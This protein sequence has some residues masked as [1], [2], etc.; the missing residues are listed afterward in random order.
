M[1][2]RWEDRYADQVKTAAEAVALIKP[3]QRVFVGTG[4]GMPRVLVDALVGRAAELAD[5]EVVQL[6]AVGETPFAYER[7][8]RNFRV[9]TFFVTTSLRH[10]VQGGLAE[11]IPIFFSDIPR[12]FD[13]G[14]IP[15]D[16][17]L[18]SVSPPDER[19][20]CT[21]G[22]SVDV[23]KSAAR[24]ATLVIAQ[25]NPLLPR[26]HGDSSIFVY[27]LDLLVPAS[28][29]LPEL[30][31]PEVDETMTR[32]GRHVAA[33]IEDG[34]TIEL[35]IGRVPHAVVQCLAGKRDLGLH[36]E[37]VTDSVIDL[38]ESG[39][40]TG[41][42]KTVDKGKIVASFAIGTR[43][44]YDF[45]DG[46]PAFA[47]QPTE[48][49][50]D[51]AVIASQYRMVAVNSALQVDL[52][53]QIAADSLG[54]SF[55]SGIGGQVDFNRG[56]AR[57][58]E[59]KAIIALPSTALKG[60][61]SRI[62][63][64]LDQGSG[65]VT[66][67]GDVQ[68]V[69]TEYGVAYLHGKSVQERAMA[70]IT[71]AHPDFRESLLQEAIAAKLLPPEMTDVQG[72]WTGPMELRTSLLL[73]DGT[74]ISFRPIHPTD[75]ESLRDFFYGMS[76]QSRYYRYMEPMNFAPAAQF[77]RFVYVDH[78]SNVRIVGTLPRPGAE[79][80]VATAGYFL[81]PTT[82]RAEVAF[83]VKDEWQGRSIGTFMLRLLQR[84]A[85][86]HG[87]AGF[88]AEV[89]RVNRAMQ[90][91]FEKAQGRVQSRVEDDVVIFDIDF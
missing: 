72:V 52:T 35:G 78:R 79:E 25:V 57:S 46:N 74:C 16:V 71:I 50:N 26:T 59:G 18:I 73:D 70:L 51:P 19:G 65:V 69:V 11:Y 81:D 55:F 45:I 32:I 56:A 76:A 39:A 8:R 47:F 12:L 63:T 40:V 87:I 85:K 24:N 77:R 60:K 27:D 67:R 3:G 5:V 9:S 84:V 91:V 36:T 64:R 4:A 80:I 14:E 49:V 15:L 48:Y 28:G 83:A 33:L 6:L 30:A 29:A 38:V 61:M 86:S 89:L 2:E 37:L 44:L 66:T 42:K 7:L 58:E 10:L 22:V 43:R 90:K 68:Y 82:N 20:V 1:N 62:V 53:G 23:V 13:K 31:A 88:T 21:L 41:A 34:S 17:A 75:E 54:G